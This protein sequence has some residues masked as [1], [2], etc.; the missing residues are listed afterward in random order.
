MATA[1]TDSLY[2]QAEAYPYF[3]PETVN[4]NVWAEPSHR[5]F[6]RKAGSDFGWDWGPAYATTGIAG[7]VYLETAA[8]AVE[9]QSIDATVYFRADDADHSVATVTVRVPVN[10]PSITLRNVTFSAFLN[11]ERQV[12]VVRSIHDSWANGNPVELS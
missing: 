12:S 10:T 4:Y 2:E 8:S 7:H 3:V 5:S 6:I 9:L 11:N 1:P